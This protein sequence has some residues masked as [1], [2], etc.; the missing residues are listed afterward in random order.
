MRKWLKKSLAVGLA[1]VMTAGLSACGGT[2]GSGGSGGSDG[3]SGN[4][5]GSS[6]NAQLA[7]ENVYKVE[8]FEFPKLVDPENGYVNVYSTEYRNGKIYMVAEV[9]D[10]SKEENETEYDLIIMNA[11]GSDTQVVKLD[12]SDGEDD[13]AGESSEDAGDSAPAVSQ[14]DLPDMAAAVDVADP[15][16]DQNTWEYT[17]YGNFSISSDGR[18]F[19]VKNHNFED[20]SNP[21]QYVSES[22]IYICCWDSDGS[23][24]WETELEGLRSDE[25][26]AEW[27]YISALIPGKDGGLKLLLNGEN[28]YRMDV[29]DAGEIS[30]REQLSE[31]TGKVLG[32]RQNTMVRE[33]GTMVLIYSDENDWTKSYIAAYDPESDTLGES[34]E[35][36][37]SFGWNGYSSLNAG[38]ASDLIFTMN[39]GV[40]IF[41][42]G[43]EAVTKKMDFV[44]SDVNI[45]NF[46]SLVEV[47][48]DSFVGIFY[49]NYG[50]DMKAAVFTYRDPAD[51][52]DKSV[53]VLAGNWVDNAIRQR[54]VAF[55][56]AS[57][58]Y[59][60]VIR[61]YD[62]Y[63]SYDDY[64]AG[65]TRLNNDIVTGGMPDILFAE[66]LPI[67]NYIS[68]GLIADVGKLIEEDPEL[69]QVE[70]LQNV[71]DAY[72][73][74]G[75][76]YY[77]VP[78]FS[79]NT[80]IAKTS[81]VGDKTGWTL[82]E[83]QQTVASMG[84]GT[85]A[86]G[87]LTRDGFMSTAM[88]YCGNDFIDVTTGKCS[89]NTEN[90]ISMMEYAKT[91]PEELDWENM[92]NDNYWM[93]YESQYRENR[94]LL[95]QLYISSMDN[96][97]YSLNGNF[98]EPVTFI[99]FP[100]ESGKG[101]YISANQSFV[102]S[103][104]SANLEGAWEFLRYYLTDEYQN[105]I[106]WGLS[107]NKQIF[108]ERA[109]RATQ[110]P[111]YTDENGNEVEYEET[112]YIN[113]EDIPLEPLSQEQVDQI[114]D[115]IMSVDRAY[116]YNENV[117]NII[118][119]EMGAF[120]SGQKSAQ[121]VANVI[122]SRAQIYVDENR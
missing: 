78:N 5:G 87:E 108:M 107:V 114:T 15:G 80:M 115:F 104:K 19:G 83:M 10:W 64:N 22:H 79:V 47:D 56:R 122:Q 96:L 26:G 28:M 48:K 25:E 32:N 72:S 86:I 8:E 70:F 7:K 24:L 9:S 75:K 53:V 55:N 103:A 121:D 14:Q 76:L 113:G 36:P 31:E 116:Y 2:G 49:E 74:D 97:K 89:F 18:I 92:Y 119:E 99:G 43:D 112:F 27:I 37:A 51:I 50:D 117:L 90:F 100:T 110:K 4:R 71:F 66:N 84:E 6:A 63:N 20:Y 33:D 35:M 29:S 3:G 82:E 65:F 23:R 102:L 42:K 38:M 120:Y 68:K 118:N 44:N 40:Y 54:A 60:I 39:D 1:L 101:S 12:T 11:D 46:V 109:Q 16:V 85:Q 34:S 41:N 77:V 52:P 45:S 81:L 73:V 94:T 17:G 57:D 30:E 91:L 62:S 61:E 13:S 67:E 88:Q 95:M 21:E 58:T 69:S 106:E 105:E 111:T 93:T 59:R 98:G